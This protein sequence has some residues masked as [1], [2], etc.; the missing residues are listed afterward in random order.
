MTT[1]L[2]QLLVITSATAVLAT[3][4]AALLVPLRLETMVEKADVIIIGELIRH[5][6]TNLKRH[7]F[8][9]T[10]ELTVYKATVSVSEVLK[11]DPNLKEIE[12]FHTLHPEDAQL[13]FHNLYKTAVYFL[14]EDRESPGGFQVVGGIQGEVIIRDAHVKLYWSQK[15]IRLGDFIEDIES[16]LAKNKQEGKR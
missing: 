12:V 15:E 9:A 5:E 3:S 8:K 13:R 6:K 1:R 2:F 7:F 4:V 10:K 16:L 14:N 11:G